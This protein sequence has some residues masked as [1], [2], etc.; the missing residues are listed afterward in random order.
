MIELMETA[1][2]DRLDMGFDENG[3]E[4]SRMW[5]EKRYSLLDRSLI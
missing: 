4:N 3:A 2:K 5:F 1:V